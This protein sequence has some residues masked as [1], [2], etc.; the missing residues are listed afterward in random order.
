[1]DTQAQLWALVGAGGRWHRELSGH[2]RGAAVQMPPAL[3]GLCASADMQY[4]Y[5][6]LWFLVSLSS[7][8]LFPFN[9]ITQNFTRRD[10]APVVPS[11]HG[12]GGSRYL[13]LQAETRATTAHFWCLGPL[14]TAQ[15]SHWWPRWPGCRGL[16]WLFCC[17]RDCPAFNRFPAPR[18]CLACLPVSLP[19]PLL[20]SPQGF[21]PCAMP[22]LRR[23]LLCSGGLAFVV[24]RCS[25]SS[26]L[27]LPKDFVILPR[28]FSPTPDCLMVSGAQRQN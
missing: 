2:I 13:L 10:S 17:V 22:R 11:L 4:F 23:F 12:T 16:G 18:L 25:L 5:F 6:S 20:T 21:P 28:F 26:L 24:I 19:S 14:G 1:M 7:K 27:V 15:A 3:S 9:N 8:W